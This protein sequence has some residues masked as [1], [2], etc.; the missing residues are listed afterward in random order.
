VNEFHSGVPVTEHPSA[1]DIAAYLSG[2]LAQASSVALEQHLVE[3][4]ECRQVVTSARRVLRTHR[5]PQRLV[6]MVPSAAAA[7]LLIAVLIRVPGSTVGDEPLRSD[8]DAAGSESE[9]TIAVVAPRDGEVVPGQPIVFV[10]RAQNGGPLYRLSLTEAS[11]RQM[12]SGETTDTTLS[13]PAE[14]P[15]VGGQTYFW[16]VDALGADGR[17]LTSRSKRFSIAP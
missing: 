17:S 12:W 11:G 16:S 13:M 9:L 14:V 4:A 6:W 15:V 5:A 8:S 1:E 3:C 7:M 10:W 2:R